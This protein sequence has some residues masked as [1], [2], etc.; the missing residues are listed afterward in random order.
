MLQS[1]GIQ[2]HTVSPPYGKG[3]MK[4]QKISPDGYIQMSVQL[5]FYNMHQSFAKTYEP[6]TSRCARSSGWSMLCLY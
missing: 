6:A 3:F 5:A 2:I 1:S 4:K